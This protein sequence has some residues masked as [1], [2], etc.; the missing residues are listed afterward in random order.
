MVDL[1]I[2]SGKTKNF[3]KL[4]YRCTYIFFLISYRCLSSEN[5]LRYKPHNAAMIIN[6]C[7]TLRNYL[8]VNGITDEEFDG[9]FDI[10]DNPP[11]V[12]ENNYLLEGQIQRNWLVNYFTEN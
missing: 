1:K 4:E 6:A 7:A 3:N 5:L 8:L 12:G 2:V 11:Y 10:D 9:N